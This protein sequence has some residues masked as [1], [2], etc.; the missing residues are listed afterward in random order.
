MAQ[1]EQDVSPC[2]NESEPL[3]AILNVPL[4][5]KWLPQIILVL[6]KRKGLSICQFEGNSIISQ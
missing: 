3:A 5:S 1:S 4:G 2:F 6:I